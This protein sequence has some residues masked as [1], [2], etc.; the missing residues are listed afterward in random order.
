[1]KKAD[2]AKELLKNYVHHLNSLNYDHEYNKS[3]TQDVASLTA[4][5]M[6][7]TDMECDIT[8]IG[9]EINGKWFFMGAVLTFESK[10]YGLWALRYNASD[11]W[12][13]E[14]GFKQEALKR[15]PDIEFLF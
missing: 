10:K 13:F 15:F 7:A 5:S 8:S 3:D 2:M 4:V 11:M 9:G 12:D 1:M 6:V 14:K